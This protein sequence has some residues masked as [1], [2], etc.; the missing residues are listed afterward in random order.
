M[1]DTTSDSTE[2]TAPQVLEDP[3]MAEFS[4]KMNQLIFETAESIMQDY[5]S[6]LR[7]VSILNDATS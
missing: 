2:N 7:G 3:K 6:K 4:E 5:A 1:S